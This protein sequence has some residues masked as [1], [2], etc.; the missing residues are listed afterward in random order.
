MENA[1]IPLENSYGCFSGSIMVVWENW[2]YG[3]VI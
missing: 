2:N 1:K 3:R